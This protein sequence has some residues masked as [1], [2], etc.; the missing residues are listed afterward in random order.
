MGRSNRILEKTEEL[1]A[2][3]YHQIFSGKVTPVPTN[4][5]K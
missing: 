5:Q 1:P 3:T 4:A 2:Y